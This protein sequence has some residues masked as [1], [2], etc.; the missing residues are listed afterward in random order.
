M[1]INKQFKLMIFIII[2]IIS[3]FI[4]LF[5]IV[6]IFSEN[7]KN[8][9]MKSTASSIAQN[10]QAVQSGYAVLPKNVVAVI[11][12]DRD[13][14]EKRSIVYQNN[15]DMRHLNNY[16]AL[17]NLNHPKDEELNIMVVMDS[18]DFFY[19]YFLIITS[20]VVMVFLIFSLIYVIVLYSRR[21]KHISRILSHADEIDIDTMKVLFSNDEDMR[22]IIR[23]IEHYRL[24]F[25]DSLK[26]YKKRIRQLETENNALRNK[27]VL[28]TGIIENVSHELKSPLTK[29]KG[30]L[31]YI[32]SGKM[33][34]LNESQKSGILIARKNVDA[35]LHQIEQIM[36]YAKDETVVLDKEMFSLQKLIRDIVAV[37]EQEAEE[38]GVSIELN[39]DNLSKPVKGNRVALY[40]VYNNIINN[41]LK[42]TNKNGIISVIGYLKLID[43]TEHAIVKISDSGIGVPAGKFDRIFE[44]F[45]Q[46]EQDENRKYPGMGLGL[47]IAKNIIREHRG[48]IEV[49]S[50]VGRGSEFTIII[51]VTAEEG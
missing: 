28:K 17:F 48:S 22:F 5:S 36:N 40:E 50:I 3:F 14:F 15:F 34:N 13:N 44:R 27:D 18:N 7:V 10:I 19:D 1:G 37:Y 21:K 41:A 39:I 16:S 20:A 31:D 47:T 25:S 11:V 9:N 38:K 32:H 12:Y 2:F 8:G 51:P 23:L 24:D 46:I 29:V 42:F 45:Y 49:N 33:G 6:D 43:K 4:I 26:K 35:L 30:Y